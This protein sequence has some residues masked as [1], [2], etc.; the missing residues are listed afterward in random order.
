VDGGMLSN[1]PLELFISAESKVTNVMG[2]KQKTP[3]PGLMIDESLEVPGAGVAAG[4]RDRPRP[5]R[6]S[7]P[8]YVAKDLTRFTFF[9]SS[10]EHPP[11]GCGGDNKKRK[12]ELP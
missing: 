4:G 9:L 5:A 1:F 11:Q 7:S 10:G 3:V 8:R 12:G 2:P 6:L